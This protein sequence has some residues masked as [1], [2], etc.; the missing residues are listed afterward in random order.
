MPT[1]KQVI[2]RPR[3]TCWECKSAQNA[4]NANICSFS[5]LLRY[6]TLQSRPASV[7]R[8]LTVPL[9]SRSSSLPPNNR[10]RA[11]DHR[12]YAANTQRVTLCL[13][14]RKTSV[15]EPSPYP[16]PD[17]P[18]LTPELRPRDMTNLHSK[19]ISVGDCVRM[20]TNHSDNQIYRASCAMHTSYYNRFDT[21]H[22]PWETSTDPA[23]KANSR[24]EDIIIGEEKQQVGE[25]S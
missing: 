2:G 13:P 14:L 25:E 20:N 8:L 11:A 18:T 17:R 16:P 21:L 7:P 22:G 10:A 12:V 24:I 6:P 4:H 5:D 3:P 9:P 15:M 19:A 23:E 1:L